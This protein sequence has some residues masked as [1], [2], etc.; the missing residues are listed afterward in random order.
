MLNRV[1]LIGAGH[2]ANSSHLRGCAS[3]PDVIRR[4]MFNGASN[5]CSERGFDC[6]AGVTDLGDVILD[7]TPEGVLALTPRL[8]QICSEGLRPLTLGGDHSITYPLVAAI[9]AQLGQVDILHFDAHGDIYPDFQ[10]NPYS[11]ASPFARIVEKG[12]AGRVVQVGIRTLN[13]TQRDMIA[14][15]GVETHE[16]RTGALEQI[17]LTF[18]RPLY[19]SIDIDALDPAFAP[20]VSHH[21]PGGM[22]CND[23]LST[24]ARV[25]ADVVAA[26]VVEFNPS[27][28]WQDMTAMVCVKFVKELAAL[29]SGYRSP[30]V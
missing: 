24:L 7:D 29:L 21:E 8:A 5:L 22:S 20:G 14:K 3:A 25:E 6:A 9:H 13:P 16:W 23:I 26:D 27:R 11:H 10:G 4:V 30:L 19:I 17:D 28:D 18:K 15:Y 12:L 1:A 2:D